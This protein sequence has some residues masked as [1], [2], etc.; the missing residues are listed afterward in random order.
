MA[1]SLGRPSRRKNEPGIFPAAYIRS[2]M[3]TVRG[4]KSIPSLTPLAALAVTSTTVSP[5]RP[6]TAPWDWGA[7]FPVS[8]DSVLSVPLIGTWTWMASAIISPCP[9]APRPPM[10]WSGWR[11][12]S[13]LSCSRAAGATEGVSARGPGDWQLTSWPPHGWVCGAWNWRA[14]RSPDAAGHNYG[15]PEGRPWGSASDAE[16]SDERPVALDV[17]ISQV[18][19]EPL[20]L[21]DELHE[22]SSGVMVVL[23]LLQVLREVGDALLEQGDLN[24]GGA[25]V[26]RVD[27]VIGNRCGFLRHAEEIFHK[28]G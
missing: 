14:R 26:G 19:P 18:G 21:P 20:L 9:E 25:G 22:A 12:S 17:S 3:S 11:A 7:S 6:T 10:G 5:M 27:P 28:G 13:Q 24:L 16:A 15:R 8:R 2:S 4:K 23:V 1:E